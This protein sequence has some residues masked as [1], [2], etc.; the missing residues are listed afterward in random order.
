VIIC[1]GW[2]RYSN[3]AAMPKLPPPPRSAQNRRHVAHVA[4]GRHE[5]DRVHVVG[6]Q[7][8]LRHQPAETAAECEPGDAGGRDRTT[9]HGEP[10]GV[11]LAIQ[12]APEHA[13][14]RPYGTRARVD[15]DPLHR[16]QIDHQRPVDHGTSRNVVTAATHADVEVL[17]AREPNGVRDVGSALAARDQRRVAVDQSVVDSARFLVAAV[18]RR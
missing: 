15:I 10:V 3:D 12:L 14:L 4:F 6:R 18:A 8:V 7:P 5:L 2:S 1:N 16:A 13:P 9:G 11:G 17:C